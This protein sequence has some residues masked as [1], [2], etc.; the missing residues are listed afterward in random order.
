[1]GGMNFEAISDIV[2]AVV[3]SDRVEWR[4][5]NYTQGPETMQGRQCASSVAFMGK[6]YTFGGCYMFSQKRMVRECTN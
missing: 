6:I 3:L 1:M 2:E 5:V 4:K